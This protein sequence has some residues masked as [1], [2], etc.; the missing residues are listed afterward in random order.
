[1]RD[2]L[3]AEEIFPDITGRYPSQPLSRLQVCDGVII[4][5][6]NA[7]ATMGQMGASYT[8]DDL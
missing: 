5:L 6:D 7:F 2:E 3:F 4:V 1:M 8:I